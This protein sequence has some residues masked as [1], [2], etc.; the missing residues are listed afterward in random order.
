MRSNNQGSEDKEPP[1]VSNQSLFTPARWVQAFFITDPISLMKRPP[2]G[3][4]QIQP[5]LQL[6]KFD[7]G[8]MV[9]TTIRVRLSRER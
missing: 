3:S 9:L 1:R 7:N 5:F 4:D 6:T 2:R 8:D